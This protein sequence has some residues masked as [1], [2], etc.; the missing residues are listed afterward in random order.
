MISRVHSRFGT[1]GMVVAVIALVVALAGGAYAAS[2]GLT[3]KQKKQV[4]KIAQT[5]AKKFATAG[6]QGPPGPPG[7]AGAPGKDGSNGTDGTDGNSVV[8]ENEAPGIKCAVGGVN[9][10]VEESQTKNYVCNGQTG[11]VE[12]LPSGS[13]LKG[14]FSGTAKDAATAILIPIS[15]EIEV[16][17]APTLVY[18]VEGG[19]LAY[20]VDSAGTFGILVEEEVEAVCPGDPGSPEAEPGYVCLYTEKAEN[21]E[22]DT[23]GFVGG[24]AKPSKYGVSLPLE[25]AAGA[26]V[27][28]VRGTWAVQAE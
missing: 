17:P 4:K 14:V 8:V 21:V 22:V 23:S 20:T 26:E 3:A 7:P 10:E 28:A 11:F 1:A 18:I 15:F 19:E 13:S 6:P 16:S 5:E 25:V 9:V 24:W 27:G 2:G 12:A